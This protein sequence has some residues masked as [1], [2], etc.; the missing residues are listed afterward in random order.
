MARAPRTL[1]S[2]AV[3]APAEPDLLDGVS[4]PREAAEIVGHNEARALIEEAFARSAPQAL[5][6]VGPRGIGKATLAFRLARTLLTDT[7]VTAKLESD[8]DHRASHQI[9]AGTHPGLLH[10]TRPYDEKTKRN[11][12]D[13][14]VDVVRRVVPFLGGT[15][16]SG[17][18]R[19]VI[20]D[21]VD[22]LNP[23]AANALLK[24][25]EEPPRKTL[26]VLIAHIAGKVLPTLR[27]RCRAI[28]LRPLTDEDVAAVLSHMDR[29]KG[30]A[31]E[32][33][34]SVRRA[35]AM[36]GAG[37]D[38]IARARRLLTPEAMKDLRQ[39]HALADLA[40]QRRDDNFAVIVDLVLD[41]FAARARAGAATLPP[42][43]LN[44]YA[45]VFMG[46]LKERRGV[47]ILNLDRKEFVLSLCTALAD[48]DR[49]AQRGSSRR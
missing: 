11:K 13:L 17:G 28:T 3:A 26:F 22:D 24:S 46:A 36:D 8:P 43:A 4:P 35:L 25:L 15:A 48:A 6:L 47:E 10:L 31:T 40:A 29:N 34:G 33:E 18:W 49:L 19:V 5:L 27:S 7:P 44:A 14:T 42:E 37:A 20:V 32:A 30:L 9:G 45:A 38:V 2:E 23:N 1:K 21:A 12:A 39:H 16:A 41:T